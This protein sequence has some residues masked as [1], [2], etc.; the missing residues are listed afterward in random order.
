MARILF[1]D[2]DP[3]TLETLTKAAEVLGHQAT[4]ASTGREAIAI[5]ESDAD[6]PDLIFTDMR[7]PDTDGAELVENMRSRPKIAQ[8]P[9]FILSASPIEDA[10]ERADA[11]GALGYLDK[12]I[13]LTTLMQIINEHTS[14]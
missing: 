14:G 2:D 13:R 11:A 5:I 3:F 6:L 4:T 8:I 9:M 10:V 7:L 12:P 1:I